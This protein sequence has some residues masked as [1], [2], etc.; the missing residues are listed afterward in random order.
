MAYR[1]RERP[2]LTWTTV[3]LIALC[4]AA[5]VWAQLGEHHGW[6][7]DYGLVPERL[8]R[9]LAAGQYGALGHAFS[10]VF[11]HYDWLHL[12]GNM[13]FL[14]LFAQSVE[15]QLGPGNALAVGLMGGVLANLVAAW[16]YPQLNL[17]IIGA[18]G[19]TAAYLGAFMALN[20]RSPVGVV[21]PLGLYWPYVQ[22]PA[23]ALLAIWLLTQILLTVTTDYVEVATWF[24]HLAGFVC[25]LI[26]T[27]LALILGVRRRS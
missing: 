13:A 14:W 9:A 6:H 11:V 15:R 19:A 16:Q 17:P 8:W 18:S 23:L 5:F 3:L 22:A 7:R 12:I 1:R 2:V 24:T 25:G 27:G 4:T 21:L 20:P 10:A 26:L